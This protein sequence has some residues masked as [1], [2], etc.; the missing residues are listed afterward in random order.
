MIRFLRAFVYMTKNYKTKVK[1]TVMEGLQCSY[2]STME[3][4]LSLPQSLEPSSDSFHG[5]LKILTSEESSLLLRSYDVRERETKAKG[6]HLHDPGIFFSSR[7]RFSLPLCVLQRTLYSI[8]HWGWRQAANSVH[9]VPFS[10]SVE[11]NRASFAIFVTEI[12]CEKSA[13]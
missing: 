8:G 5:S 1:N 6:N 4:V 12:S 10:V 13:S 11:T 9:L 3:Q 7:L 2:D